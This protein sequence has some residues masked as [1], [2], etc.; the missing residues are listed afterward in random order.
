MWQIQFYSIFNFILMCVWVGVCILYVCACECLHVCVY[1][2]MLDI[3]NEPSTPSLRQKHQEV[4][5]NAAAQPL[6]AGLRHCSRERGKKERESCVSAAQCLTAS[7][8]HLS[9]P[10][11]KPQYGASAAPCHIPSRFSSPPT[12]RNWGKQRKGSLVNHDRALFKLTK[13]IIEIERL[14]CNQRP[15]FHMSERTIL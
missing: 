10:G 2:H 13:L 5:L 7:R 6:P 12:Y 14:N 15:Y 11:H 8:C 9:L 3:R 4:C 1:S